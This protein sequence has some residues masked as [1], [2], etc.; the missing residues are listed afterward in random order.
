MKKIFL[1]LIFIA[2]SAILLQPLFGQFTVTGTVTDENQ[3]PLP[4]ANVVVKGVLQGAVT[5][6]KGYYSISVP[7]Q[8][9]VLVFSYI[10]YLTAEETVNS[11]TMINLSLS[12][13]LKKLEEVVVVGYGTQKKSNLTGSVAVV[14]VDQFA[15]SVST[16]VTD[17]LMGRVAGVSVVTSGA[18]G[19]VGNI[20]IRGTSFISGLDD[21]NK[22]LFVVDGVLTDDSPNLNPYDIESL[23]V[24]KDAASTAIYG[25]RAASGV[26]LI[27]TKKGKSGKPVIDVTAQAGL[28]S[29]P[30]RIKVMDNGEFARVSNAQHDNS[31]K[32]R[33]PLCDLLFNPAVNT[34]WQAEVFD[35][36][37]WTQ[38]YNISLSSGGENYH[39]YFSVNGTSTEGTIN[40]SSF[41]RIGAR[42]NNDYKPWKK[43]TIGQNLAVS[44]S[45][46]SGLMESYGENV[47]P[48]AVGDLPI[49]PV[50]DSTTPSGYGYGSSPNGFTYIPNPVA[51]QELLH[52]NYTDYRILGN[53]FLDF[54][55]VKGLIY[56]FSIGLNTNFY[57]DKEYHEHLYIRYAADPIESQSRFF[58][59]RVE[60]NEILIENRLT[61]TKSIGSHNFSLMATYTEQD[62]KSSN[63]ESESTG[64]Y[65]EEPYYWVIS[66]SKEQNL[67]NGTKNESVLRS[68]LGRVTYNYKEKYFINFSARYDGSSKFTSIDNKRWGFFPS[69]SGG[70]DL[71]KEKFMQIP[72]I[73]QFK[74]RASYG[75]VG[76]TSIGDYRYQ[77]LITSNA[78]SSGVNYNLGTDGHLV[79]GA[80]R[81]T[82]SDLFISWE[83]LKEKNFGLDLILFNGQIEFNADYYSGKLEALLSNMPIPM[84][85]GPPASPDYDAQILTNSADM[86]RS[87]LEASLTY[88]RV[89]GNFKF[90]ISANASHNKNEVTTLPA[91]VKEIPGDNS[92]TRVGLP[93]GQLFL[94][95]YLGIYTSQEQ[96][97][98][99]HLLIDGK[100]PVIGDARY[101]DVNGRDP[102]TNELTGNPD[103]KISFDDDRQVWGNP[104]SFLQYGFNLNASWKKLDL[105]IFFQ[106]VTKRDVY[107]GLYSSLNTDALSNHSADYNPYIDG[108]GKDPRPM[109][110]DHPNNEGTTT[111]FV[112]NGGYLRL[113]N[114]QIGYTLP[115]EKLKDL[116]IWIGG[117]NL[118]TFTKYKG[119][120][121]EFEGGVFEPG[122]DGGSN[123]PQI[124]TFMAGF[125]L[126]F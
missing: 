62:S 38:D 114:L 115:I 1:L 20:K 48:Y 74:L 6:T 15:Q 82:L 70:W 84:T 116:R 125:N 87:G 121:P 66:A 73:S 92:I 104:I 58:E 31:G 16:N 91:G 85:V 52:N 78:S 19:D 26:I 97:E 28:Q 109:M 7:N 10:G 88:K 17:R 103:G 83:T 76:N 65:E 105:S 106:G 123:Y 126:K 72:A 43:L 98:N 101:R 50:Y 12:P 36:Q 18:P 11:R 55:P 35:K 63:I 30:N 5:D 68:Y 81:G 39:S 120:D 108:V 4:G 34:D 90:S 110:G 22:P 51:M 64:G 79:I 21:S 95:E 60:D 107:N 53:L 54:E 47:V 49:I 9:S 45:V 25:S 124:R 23:Q 13:D 56:H 77:S 118:L 32:K 122:I 41:Q 3:Q 59:R 40:G 113:K 37:A 69:I 42:I 44:R 57:H 86:K 46:T 96:I 71:A 67:A 8:E 89:I 75:E 94:V 100:T 27:T 33:D 29:I 117:S 2:L 102:V 111:R 14:N 93:V 80:T 99:D 61:Y 112:E 119:M 24:L